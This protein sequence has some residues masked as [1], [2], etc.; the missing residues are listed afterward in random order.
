MGFLDTVP[1][2]C[3][4]SLEANYCS[5][6]DKDKVEEPEPVIKMNFELLLMKTSFQLHSDWLLNGSSYCCLSSSFDS[7]V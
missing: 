3:S 4:L 6:F 7:F 2:L 5:L 1:A